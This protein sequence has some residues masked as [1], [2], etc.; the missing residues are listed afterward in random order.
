MLVNV[1]VLE[2]SFS[3]LDLNEA[4]NAFYYVIVCFLNLL[5]TVGEYRYLCSS[6]L[7]AYSN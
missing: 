6:F 4:I 5:S 3:T 7:L 1:E 2:F